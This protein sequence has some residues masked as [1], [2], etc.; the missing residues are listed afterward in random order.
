V[1]DVLGHKEVA[2][3]LDR[4][5]HALPTLQ[6]EAM[7]RLDEVLGRA[8]LD[9]PAEGRARHRLGICRSTTACVG[10]RRRKPG[11][12]RVQIGAGGQR[13]GPIRVQIGP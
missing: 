12:K 6:G 9:A 11:A 4:Y 3:A 2:I 10:N 13:E 5:R 1:S 8:P 7:G